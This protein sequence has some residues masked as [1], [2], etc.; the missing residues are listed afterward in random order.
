[1]NISHKESIAKESNNTT[2]SELR[3]FKILQ[4]K[5]TIIQITEAKRKKIFLNINVAVKK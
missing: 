5:F 3:S 2:K 4:V 1:M